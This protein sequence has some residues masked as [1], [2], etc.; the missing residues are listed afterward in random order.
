L[1]I[2]ERNR[3]ETPLSGRLS[4]NCTRNGAAVKMSEKRSYFNE[5]KE[6]DIDK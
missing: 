1:T 2:L 4:L 5:E 6:K 3:T